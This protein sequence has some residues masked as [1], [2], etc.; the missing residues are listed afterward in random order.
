MNIQQLLNESRNQYLY[1]GLDKS[2]KQSVVLWESAGYAIKEAALTADQIQQLFTSIEQGATAGGSNRT[3]LG[4]G[5]DAATAVN[6]A[7]E[8]L[9]SKVQDSAPIKAVD[10][11][12]D[13]VVAKIEQGLGGSDNK[14]NQVIQKYRAFAKAHPVAQGLIYSALIAAAGISGAGLGGAAVLGLLKMTDKLLQGE[15]FSSAAY[16]GAKTGAAAFAASKVADLFKAGQAQG[17]DAATSGPTQG[18]TDEQVAYLDKLGKDGGVPIVKDN[19]LW[20]QQA[21]GRL[22]T[23][24]PPRGVNPKAMLKIVNDAAEGNVHAAGNAIDTALANKDNFSGIMIANQPVIPGEPLNAA[25]M[26]AVDMSKSMGNKINPTVQAAYDAAKTAAG[27]SAIDNAQ[28]LTAS[29]LSAVEKALAAGK[30]L[31]PQLQASYDL[32]VGD[33]GNRLGAAKSGWYDSIERDSGKKLSEGQVYL[34]F[35][36]VCASQLNEGVWDSIKGAA[37]KVAGAAANKAQTVGHNLTT[38]VTA[39]KLNKAWQAAGS[40]MD[41]NELAA[42]LKQQGVGDDV[43]AK[44]Y[45]SLRIAS[46]RAAG[47]KTV[48]PIAQL[49]KD[50][51]QMDKRNQQR[52]LAYL[53]KSMGTA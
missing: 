46:P 22:Q 24:E 40:P 14:I 38:K 30:K 39:D 8:D 53:Q 50:L 37:G 19:T 15:K 18:L 31:S 11:K 4:K 52:L 10:Q 41:S 48:S 35:N 28:E 34:V 16:S 51:A 33:A 23:L 42:F 29:Q 6:K 21:D 2:E 32:T 27:N 47:T 20:V 36:T 26:A 7:W 45:K 12:Y 49:K 44:T 17:P 1:E 3:M 25:Q 5:K 13:D 43:I 9:K